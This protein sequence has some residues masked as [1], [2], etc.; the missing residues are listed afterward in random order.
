MESPHGQ[1][2]REAPSLVRTFCFGSST[3]E[4]FKKPSTE[5]H[6][7]GLCAVH[8]HKGTF[9]RVMEAGMNTP[10][11]QSRQKSR[12]E[13]HFA[14]IWSEILLRL[15][16]QNIRYS[17]SRIKKLRGRWPVFD[18][19]TIRCDLTATAVPKTSCFRPFGEQ[20]RGRYR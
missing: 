8:E 3:N 1:W 15:A 20:H 16:V 5:N 14:V 13:I 2:R 9:L 6:D 19:Q 17:I 12:G 10:E 18:Q 4:G 7:A 11:L